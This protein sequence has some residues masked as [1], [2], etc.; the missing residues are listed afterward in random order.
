MDS[1][2]RFIFFT[3]A[4]LMNDCEEKWGK[5]FGERFACAK[6]YFRDTTN[7]KVSTRLY[8][9]ESDDAF[10]DGNVLEL[11]PFLQ[12][13]S[14][15]IAEDLRHWESIHAT[16]YIHLGCDGEAWGRTLLEATLQAILTIQLLPR[17]DAI[18]VWSCRC[19]H[20]FVRTMLPHSYH[21]IWPCGENGCDKFL[22]TVVKISQS[23]DTF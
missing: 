12:H 20:Q 18:T 2:N 15:L 14:L 7:G 6:E 21:K 5:I 8:F 4:T 11:L 13:Y 16:V 10:Y 23:G 1:I 3:L 9:N 17:P 19:I 22:E